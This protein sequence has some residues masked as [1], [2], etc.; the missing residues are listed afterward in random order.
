MLSCRA[1]CFLSLYFF[2]R[3]LGHPIIHPS[4]RPSVCPSVHLF[5]HPS[6]HTF[7]HLLTHSF[8]HLFLRLF[9][10]LL[11]FFWTIRLLLAFVFVSASFSGFFFFG[12]NEFTIYL[13]L[14]APVSTCIDHSLIEY[15]TRLSTS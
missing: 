14:P 3:S 5:I 10:C 1:M 7:A 15:F 9:M 4:V 12:L 8:V 11:L 13:H 2:N 6:I